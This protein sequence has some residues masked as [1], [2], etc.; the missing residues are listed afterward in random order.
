MK[1]IRF[2][3][4]V[5]ALVLLCGCAGKEKN[6]DAPLKDAQAG[7]VISDGGFAARV[8]EWIYYINGDNFTRMENERFHEFAGALCRMKQD[9]S[10]KDIVVDRDVSVF[11]IDGEY[12]YLCFYEDLTS[13]IARVKLDGSD[14][15]VF[16][17]IDDIYLGGCYG[18]AQGYIYY[19][20]NYYLYRLDKDGK[21][22]TQLTNFK[23]YNLRVGEN[24]TY[25]TREEDGNIGNAYKIKNGEN[26]Y[27]QITNSPA[28]V[29]KTGDKAYYYML[30]NN[31][32][33]QY[34]PS[35]D[36]STPIIHGGFTEY[37]F[38][39]Y[40]YGV[41]TDNEDEI[42]IYYIPVGGGQRIQ[43]SE[44]CGKCM[45]YYDGYIYYIN[46]SKLNHLYRCAVDGSKDE[47]IS[48]E[49]I[50]DFDTLDIVD[51]YLYFLSDSDY[52]RIY[53]L[54][55]SNLAIECVELEGVSLVG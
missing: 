9:G 2:I 49:F 33:Y 15:K 31:K 14:F 5:L 55:T 3:V 20:K 11:N 30:S 21:N 42:G 47:L 36:K 28:Y 4:F 48:E 6:I 39:D 24:Y 17:K 13:K 8:G 54:N 16:K 53:R 41:S 37:V 52:D 10:R 26:E 12:I 46:T 38:F 7:E 23:V 1:K 34:S 45:A 32:V 50:Y 18:Y 35:E 51:N 19:T 40:G 29:L 43:L 22:Q 27:L 44:N 25:F